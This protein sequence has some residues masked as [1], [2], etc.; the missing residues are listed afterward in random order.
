MKHFIKVNNINQSFLV[1]N[2]E[3]LTLEQFINS[4][5]YIL[6]KDFKDENNQITI[7]M[8]NVASVCNKDISVFRDMDLDDFIVLENDVN[9][10]RTKLEEKL[11]ELN[12][13]KL[14][15]NQITINNKIYY[16]KDNNK[17]TLR[18][19]EALTNIQEIFKD[20]N[21][22]EI[23]PYILAILLREKDENGNLKQIDESLSLAKECL[24]V[25]YLD[26]HQLFF[27]FSSGKTA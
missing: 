21:P 13:S 27:F 23:Y 17:I 2:I 7:R 12:N 26:V 5:K 25:K 6:D 11:T 19:Q 24:N 3:D 18:E 15:L 20:K 9:D 8:T 22:L 4:H 10:F 16:P 14:A 1:P